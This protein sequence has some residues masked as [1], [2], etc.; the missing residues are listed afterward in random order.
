MCAPSVGGYHLGFYKTTSSGFLESNSLETTKLLFLVVLS[1]DNLVEETGASV[2]QN[3]P[4][5]PVT[6]LR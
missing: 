6:D 4:A 1:P 3:M 2:P 5:L